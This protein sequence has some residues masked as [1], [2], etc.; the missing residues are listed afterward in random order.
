[1]T[2]MIDKLDGLYAKATQQGWNGY[3]MTVDGEL[4]TDDELVEYLTNA[5]LEGSRDH[6]GRV[7]FHFVHVEKDDGPADV[8][9]TGNGPTS[10]ANA[11]WI[12]EVHNAWPG[13]ARVLR[14]AKEYKRELACPDKN[15]T[16]KDYTLVRR[17]REQLFEALDAL[18]KE[19]K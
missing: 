14:A 6:E 4:P 8:C 15:Y 10:R 18:N 1:M 17:R 12:A 5:I 11:E 13:I 7:E 2:D 16:T 9:H 3:R 19:A